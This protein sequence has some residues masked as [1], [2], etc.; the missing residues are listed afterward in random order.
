MLPLI[1]LH[2]EQDRM[3]VAHLDPQL[4]DVLASNKD[5]IQR[6][7]ALFRAALLD[8]ISGMEVI[9]T[10]EGLEQHVRV[11]TRVIAAGDDCVLLEQGIALP[12][13]CIREIQ[14]S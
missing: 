14:F 7:A 11:K 3:M 10:I 4:Q 9:L 8:S 2:S 5:R 12:V 1:T 6:R 13:S